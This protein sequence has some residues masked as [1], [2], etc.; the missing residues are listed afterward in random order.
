MQ[1]RG[2]EEIEWGATQI[3]LTH[4]D[5]TLRYVIKDIRHSSRSRQRQKNMQE[6]KEL[7]LQATLSSL[8]KRIQ[9]FCKI[10]I[11]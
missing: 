3:H 5:N 8:K 2:M 7:R 11:N 4:L 6:K 9:L 1:D 10:K